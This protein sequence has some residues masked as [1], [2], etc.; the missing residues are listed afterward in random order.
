MTRQEAER[1]AEELDAIVTCHRADCESH[2]GY[3][4]KSRICKIANAI[5]DVADETIEECAK[6][7][8]R[9]EVKLTCYGGPALGEKTLLQSS[10]FRIGDEIRALKGAK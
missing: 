8:D 3:A 5:Q 9:Y 10:T 7:A 6:V 2:G 4:R 1:W